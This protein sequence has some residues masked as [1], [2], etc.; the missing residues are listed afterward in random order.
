ME[1]KFL[2]VFEPKNPQSPFA[3]YEQAHIGG[4]VGQRIYSRHGTI[5][6]ALSELSQL[7][8]NEPVLLAYSTKPIDNT[9]I[10]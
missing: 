2:L 10:V 5:E 1:P 9:F 6:T 4:Q 8:D 7:N 3:I